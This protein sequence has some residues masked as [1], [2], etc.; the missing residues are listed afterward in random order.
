VPAQRQFTSSAL[1]DIRQAVDQLGFC[2][3]AHAMHLRLVK[4]LRK[5]GFLCQCEIAA[6]YFRGP[7]KFRGR[8]DILAT[9]GRDRAGIELDRSTP[10]DKS[11]Q[12]LRGI[13]NLTHRVIV[14]RSA[15]K[16]PCPCPQGI[17]AVLVVDRNGGKVGFGAQ[18]ESA[19]KS[20]RFEF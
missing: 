13:P 2:A 20:D 18:P 15:M 1:D 17:D 16:A 12:K 7:F 10:R 5:H 14:L 11:I 9:R 8:I 4:L 3:T 19:P 6:D